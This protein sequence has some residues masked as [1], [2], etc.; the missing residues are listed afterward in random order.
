MYGH[1][2]QFVDEIQRQQ[3]YSKLLIL[4]SF[5]EDILRKLA[6][7]YG[8]IEST[9]QGKYGLVCYRNFIYESNKSAALLDKDSFEF[10]NSQRF[11]RNKIV[12][13]NGLYNSSEKHKFIKQIGIEGIESGNEFL[14]KIVSPIYLINLI[15][16]IKI[17]LTTIIYSLD[18]IS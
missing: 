9:K 14:I 15:D 1:E 12:H 17:N 3:R 5:Y 2:I 7:L 6:V 10:I 13:K 8:L 16:Q 4:F 11:V 18:R